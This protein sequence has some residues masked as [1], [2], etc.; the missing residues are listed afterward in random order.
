MLAVRLLLVSARAHLCQQAGVATAGAAPTLQP[1]R[2]CCSQDVPLVWH[3]GGDEV[4]GTS[5]C[6][7]SSSPSPSS[8][9]AGTAPTVVPWRP[10]QRPRRGRRP[11]WQWG[12]CCAVLC[13]AVPC[14]A[15]SLV[16]PSA[17]TATLCPA[18]WAAAA[19]ASQEWRGG[20]RAVPSDIR[21]TRPLF[22]ACT[23]AQT[24]V[25]PSPPL[26]CSGLHFL[27]VMPDEDSDVCSGLWMLLDRK[28]PSV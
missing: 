26:P 1:G 25:P 21:H 13:C 15:V 27:A 12:E 6:L 28:P 9:A 3:R 11:S 14:C 5:N 19:A 16:L 18:C 10:Q 4:C 8:C 24:T 20:Q 22:C 7:L 17:L 2:S 23:C